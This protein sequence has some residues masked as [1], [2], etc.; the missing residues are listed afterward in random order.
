MKTIAVIYTKDQYDL[1]TDTSMIYDTKSIE[2]FIQSKETYKCK[3]REEYM[4]NKI[5]QNKK[6]AENPEQKIEKVKEAYIKDP[7]KKS[8]RSIF[9]KRS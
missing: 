2:Y 9:Q 1:D 4:K 5:N 8:N 7:E 6:Y 3:K